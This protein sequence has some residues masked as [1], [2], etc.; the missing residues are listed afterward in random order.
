MLFIEIITIFWRNLKNQALSNIVNLIK[1]KYIV[2]VIINNR[3]QKYTQTF[4][5]YIQH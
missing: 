2:K 5:T 1:L 4:K 3:Q